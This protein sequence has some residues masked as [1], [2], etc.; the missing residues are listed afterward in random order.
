MHAIHKQTKEEF[1]IKSIE[2]HRIARMKIRHPNIVN[3]IQME[4]KV[5]NQLTH[6][7]IV[8]LYHTFQVL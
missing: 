2:K 8:T 6:P 5:L 1:A 3:E 7:N 4:K